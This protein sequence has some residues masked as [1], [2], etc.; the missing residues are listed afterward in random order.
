MSWADLTTGTAPW[1]FVV[2]TAGVLTIVSTVIGALVAALSASAAD[3]RRA[4]HENRKAEADAQRAWLESVRVA[5][6]RFIT[7]SRRYVK[8]AQALYQPVQSADGTNLWHRQ[9]QLMGPDIQPS[10]EKYW[11]LVLIGDER[12][13]E[14]ARTLMRQVRRYEPPQ[15][16]TA[17]EPLTDREWTARRA[18]VVSARGQLAQHLLDLSAHQRRTGEATAESGDTGKGL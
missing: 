8:A 17:L 9:S 18:A 3:K 14:L 15:P 13:S 4:R 7:E 10:F 5:A 2:L 6:A 16:G 11:E 12:T 1:W